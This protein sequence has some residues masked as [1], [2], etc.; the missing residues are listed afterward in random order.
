MPASCSARPRPTACC[1]RSAAA[2]RRSCWPCRQRGSPRAWL[3][4][5]GRRA[6]RRCCSPAAAAS[7]RTALELRRARRR[8]RRMA[9]AAAAGSPRGD[10]A[11]LQ[12]WPLPLAV[13]ALQKLCHDAPAL[14]CG[15]AARYFPRDVPRQRRRTRS[16]CCAGRAS[17]RASRATPST[18][19][20]AD[21]A[22]ES[23][24]E[25]GREALQTPRSGGR[26]ARL[27]ATL[28]AMNQPAAR[29]PRRVRLSVP[30]PAA[31]RPSV[32]QLVFRERGALYAAYMPMFSEGGI[33]VPTTRDYKLGED[34]YLLLVAARRPA[35]LSGRG[36]GRLDHAG[37][38]LGRPD[39]GRRRALPD[40]REE[41]RRCA[42]GSRKRSAPR[43][44]RSSPRRRSDARR[45][46]RASGRRRP[47]APHGASPVFVDSH[48]HLSSP[49]LPA[50]LPEIRAAM[51]AAG[52][53]RALCICTTLDEFDAASMRSRS[54]TTDFWCSAG[55]HP[56]DEDSSRADA[57]TALVALAQPT[58]VVAIGE[59]GLDYYRLGGRSVGRDGVAARALPRPHPRGRAMRHRRSSST[60]E[61]PRPTRSAILREEERRRG[62]AAS[63]TASPKRPR[64]RAA[65]LD[66]GFLHLVLGHPDLQE[67]RAICARSP[68]SCRS[69]AA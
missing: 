68:P 32:I 53:D 19:G 65:A 29:P 20:A 61:A 27:V 59:T 58:K 38:C 15:G 41:P 28:A 8:R 66:L 44:R 33:F 18:P 22:L 14:A 55:V 21:L 31:A 5:A 25:Q 48:C 39:P 50:Q 26:W 43:S 13:D 23:L 3:R 9:R 57:S 16:R 46:R 6:S 11:A 40:R 17:W 51:R 67:R 36:Q 63:S 34:I 4:G 54:T 24:V 30:A 60:R 1:R 12:G 64:W 62:A 69:T 2:A 42:R 37:Q 49:E 56:D 10:A 52:V 7:R 47:A 45:E 35:A